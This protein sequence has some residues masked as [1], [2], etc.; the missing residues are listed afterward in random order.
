MDLLTRVIG[1][2][3]GCQQTYEPFTG[4]FTV[5][6]SSRYRDIPRFFGKPCRSDEADTEF[7]QIRQIYRIGHEIQPK[8]WVGYQS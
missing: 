7:V 8:I 2:I 1:Q 4:R 6:I 3:C 5:Q